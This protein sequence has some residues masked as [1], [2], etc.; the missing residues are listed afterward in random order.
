MYIGFENLIISRTG[1]TTLVDKGFFLSFPTSTVNIQILETLA[2]QVCTNRF[3]DF[4]P[5]MAM[6][7]KVYGNS[8]QHVFVKAMFSMFCCRLS[9]KLTVVF[10]DIV[11]REFQ[12]Y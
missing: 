4:N 6:T 2:K 9:L 12:V 3:V 7:V 1:S 11:S 8:L 10:L 5:A